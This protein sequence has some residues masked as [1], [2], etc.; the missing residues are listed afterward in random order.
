M[1]PIIFLNESRL[2]PFLPPM[3]ASTWARRVVGRKA[4]LTPRLYTDAANPVMSV[5]IPPPIPSTKAFLS[6]P[7]SISQRQI[8]AT[9]S[10]DLLSSVPSIARVPFAS[11]PSLS[12]IPATL[13]SYT[14]NMLSRHPAS[15]ASA[16]IFPAACASGHCITLISVICFSFFTQ[17]CFAPVPFRVGRF[18]LCSVPTVAGSFRSRAGSG[19]L[20]AYRVG[21]FCSWSFS[22]VP[23]RRLRSG[24]VDFFLYR[25]FRSV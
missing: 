13:R 16:T 1:T 15:P 18:Q 10:K 22:C 2:T 19:F 17:S 12:T 21:L 8:S 11:R 7:R 5:V 6:A 3:A 14:M 9:V 25:R 23:Y 20:F 24:S 4:N